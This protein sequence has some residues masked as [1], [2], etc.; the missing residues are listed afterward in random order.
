MFKASQEFLKAASKGKKDRSAGILGR[1]LKG[2]S[3]LEAMKMAIKQGVIDTTQTAD[4]VGL[5]ENPNAKYSGNWNKAMN[6]IGWSFHHAEVFN[7]EVTFL[8]SYRLNMKKNWVIIIRLLT[9]QLRIPGTVTL[10]TLQ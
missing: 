7:R 9:R 1:I 2:G 5:A 6:V 4:L 8:T 10:I 3:E